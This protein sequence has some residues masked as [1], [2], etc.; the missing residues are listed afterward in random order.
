MVDLFIVGA[1]PAGSNL[2]R[3]AGEKHQVFLLDQRDL[4]DEYPRN[5]KAKCCGGLLAPDAQKILGEMGLGIPRDV[6]VDPQLFAVRTLDLSSG[7]EALYQ[8]H[9]YNLDREKFD[10]WL[11]SRLP[12]SVTTCFNAV[13]L[14]HEAIPG[15]FTVRYRQNGQLQEIKTRLLIGADG[16]F[17]KV[18]RAL[19]LP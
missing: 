5:R 10:R 1:G 18:R 9:Y 11:V 17:S 14:S 6:L 7:Q 3:L 19:A 2:A 16:A 13:Y 12:S 8:R 15:G 4:G